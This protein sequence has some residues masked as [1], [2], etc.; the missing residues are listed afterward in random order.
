MNY[1]GQLTII[2]ASCKALNH[3]STTMWVEADFLLEF[4]TASGWLRERL[5]CILF[6][7]SC[8][9]SPHELSKLR[10]ITQTL[11]GWQSPLWRDALSVFFL[12]RLTTK[13]IMTRRSS[14]LNPRPVWRWLTSRHV[15][16]AC[17]Y[18]WIWICWRRQEEWVEE[19]V[20]QMFLMFCFLKD[21]RVRRK[22]IESG[23]VECISKGKEV[24]MGT[25]D[26]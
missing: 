1:D 21:G 4:F 22:T 8:R 24:V 6:I 15:L 19:K 26:I 3:L 2:G 17:E 5:I 20:A 7:V 10:T 13:K 16:S 9:A 14:K 11:D 18:N 23:C 25:R 12:S